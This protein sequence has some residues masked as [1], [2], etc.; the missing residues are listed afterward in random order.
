MEQNF[1]QI[2]VYAVMATFKNLKPAA[3]V[4]YALPP[5]DESHAVGVQLEPGARPA[6]IDTGK[7]P[8]LRYGP[9]DTSVIADAM[10]RALELHRSIVEGEC[11]YERVQDTKNCPNC[12]YARIC[13]RSRASI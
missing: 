12:Y 1:W 4:Y 7:R 6:P 3:F 8:H 10:A 5:G 9:V 13:Q 2:P 11:R